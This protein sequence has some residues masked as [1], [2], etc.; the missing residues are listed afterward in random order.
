MRR[1]KLRRAAPC[2]AASSPH[3][4]G[5]VGWSPNRVPPALADRPGWCSSRGVT[6]VEK[7]QKAC[8]APGFVAADQRP[9]LDSADEYD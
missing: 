2:S 5:R 8:L 7:W 4:I 6:R 9:M 1:A 3:A